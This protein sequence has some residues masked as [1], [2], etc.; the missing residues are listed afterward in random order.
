MYF[1]EI[2]I[3]NYKCFKNK[4]TLKLEKGINIIVGKN[5][6]GKTTLLEALSMEFPLNPHRSF[7]TFPKSDRHPQESSK[8]SVT[9]TLEKDEL[10]DLILISQKHGNADFNLPVDRRWKSRIKSRNENELDKQME[11]A[12]AVTFA[13]KYFSSQTFTLK[14]QREATSNNHGNWMVLDDTYVYPDL[15]RTEENNGSS[16]YYLKFRVESSNRSFNFKETTFIRGGDRKYRDDFT[17]R[18]A[19]ELSKYVFRFLAERIPFQPCELRQRGKLESDSRNLA[20]VLNVLQGNASKF[21]KFNEAIKQILPNVYQIGVLSDEPTISSETLNKGQVIIWN[22]RKDIK[23]NHLAKT[24][25]EVGSGIGQVIAILYVVLTA[26]EPQVILIDELQ[27]F[28][29]PDAARK[30]IE[31]LRF[32]GNKH[33]IIIVTHSPTIIT[34]AQPST[35]TLIKQ[36]NSK[37]VLQ[38][39][40]INK[41]DKQRI[42]LSEI[43]AKLSDVFGYDRVIWVEG[44][45][46]EICFPKILRKL[47]NK[48]L[49]GTAILQVHSTGEFDQADEKNIDIVVDIYERLS[50]TNGGLVPDAVGYIFDKEN[51]SDEE[52]KKK[53]EKYPN[54]YFTNKRLYENYLL[55]SRAVFYIIKEMGAKSG[56]KLEDIEKWIEEKK[57][58]RRYYQPYE[59]PKDLDTWTNTIHGKRFLKDLFKEFCASLENQNYKEK[60]HSVKLTEWLLENSKDELKE[61][62]ELIERAIKN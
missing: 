23:H 45:T 48:P 38:K 61:V 37:S 40:D 33:Q 57:E 34:Q 53:R 9:F 31:T 62:A 46:E 58:I 35:V 25:D 39:I 55:N 26:E 32:Y 24:L 56:L 17:Q 19:Y 6:V 1:N 8:V 47:S 21:K 30:L 15:E 2:E 20:E 22:S 18:I 13:Q 50:S 43:G 42:Y 36:R 16:Q 7:E 52:I 54:I 28:L 29:H 27:S 14:L 11:R 4:T 5:N 41:V 12:R 59:V 44:I 51:R 49:L 3:E 10:I 60:V